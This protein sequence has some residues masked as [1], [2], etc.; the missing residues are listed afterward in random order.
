MQNQAVMGHG[1]KEK[2][3]T[4]FILS[5]SGRPGFRFESWAGKEV[6]PPIWNLADAAIAVSVIWILI[7]Q[8]SYLQQSVD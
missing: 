2:W 3:W 5:L 7:K 6:F 8:R 4:C 1:S